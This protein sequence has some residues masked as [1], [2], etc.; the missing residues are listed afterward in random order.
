MF[1][2]HFSHFI[3][4]RNP[5]TIKLEDFMSLTLHYHPLSSFCW[6]TLIALY[7]N[8]T[9]FTPH[10]VNLGDQKSR[11]EFLKIWP[12][13]QFP[14]LEDTEQNQIIPQS[15][16]IIEYLHLNYA[17]PVKLIPSDINLALET[18]RWNEFLDDYVHVQMQKIVSNSLRNADDI[19]KTGE[20]HSRKLILSAYNILEE[21]MKNKIWMVGENFSMAD[22]AAS[23]ALF[24]ANKVEPFEE[25][26][27]HLK[28]YFERLKER[29]AFAQVLIE[30]EPYFKYF[31]YK[32]KN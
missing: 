7:E 29:A 15:T 5:Q 1:L 22:C 30:A 11:E 4:Y 18:R 16:V 13:G 26:H 21:R 27:P 9:P 32:T 19:D 14:V 31:P 2:L 3:L 20:A 24:Y 23:P 6:K 28:T 12:I 25:T 17:G 8:Q 10:L